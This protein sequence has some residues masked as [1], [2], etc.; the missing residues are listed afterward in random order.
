MIEDQ[1]IISEINSV[2]MQNKDLGLKDA[3][4]RHFD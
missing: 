4:V 2:K 1:F 3:S